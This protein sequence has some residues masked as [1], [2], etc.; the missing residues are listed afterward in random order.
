MVVK[1]SKNSLGRYRVASISFDGQDIAPKDFGKLYSTDTRFR[2]AVRTA[3]SPRL[4]GFGDHVW[5]KVAARMGINKLRALPDGDDAAKKQAMDDRVRNGVTTA[6]SLGDSITCDD[7][8]TNCRDG[9]GK[10][11]TDQEVD[12]ARKAQDNFDRSK[13]TS[14]RTA[15]KAISDAVGT[16]VT[17]AVNGISNMI[18]LTGPVDSYCQVYSAVRAV[19]YAAKTIRTVQ[20]ASYA[21][22]FLNTA[23]Q[24][25]AG[26]ATPED[27]A[28]LGGI[29][30]NV[31]YDVKSGV[32]RKAG[33]DSFG[34]KYVLH[35]EVGRADS[36][37]S[38]FMAG[39]G[40]TGDL[41]A[42]SDFLAGGKYGVPR[43]VCRVV[44]NQWVQVG[45]LIG[46][47]AIFFIPGANVAYGAS[48]I[49]KAGL[50]MSVAVGLTALAP[51]LIDIIAGN[52][53]ESIVGEDATNAMVSGSGSLFSGVSRA[54]GNGT[55]T[56]DDAVAYT[57]LNNEYIALNAV[58]DRATKSPLD[59]Y[60]PHTFLGSIVSRLATS[61][62]STNTLGGSLSTIG[63]ILSNS[64]Q[65][66]V[67]T[68]SAATDGALRIAYT[69]CQDTDYQEL[70]IATDP[71][72]NPIHGI[73]VKY[74]QIDP[75]TVLDELVKK[76]QID[77]VTGEVT[78]DEFKKIIEV[79]VD[80][81]EPLG[82]GGADGLGSIEDDKNCRINDDNA[83][84]FLYLVDQRIEEG[85]DMTSAAPVAS[86][87]S[88][89]AVPAGSAAELAQKIIDSGNV[90]DRSGQ[91]SQI[92][93]GS[94]TGVD[95]RVLAAVAALSEKYKFAI[96]SIQRDGNSGVEAGRERKTGHVG[97]RAIDISGS[98]GI[99]GES[100]SFNGHKTI[101]QEFLNSAAAALPGNCLIGVPNQQYVNATK[102]QV[103][104]GCGV[105][106]DSPSTTGATG[107]HVHLEVKP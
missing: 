78:G 38:Q 95:E 31:A 48:Q 103:K 98:Y 105:F 59:P 12:D 14:G 17:G 72:C 30:T 70:G 52:V 81:D 28:Y 53:T 3:Y 60:S 15:N 90:V 37:V 96:S 68:T 99:N 43:D 36:Y 13:Q 76:G 47:I 6:S 83:Y 66:L 45:S 87:D 18:K 92:A 5:N 51:M 104:T 82:S 4:A 67:P 26:T 39:G 20:L 40:L 65:S 7:A 86:T 22:I 10:P 61:A 64:F 21:M 2:S 33:M 49:V 32:K 55:M 41:I 91:L 101:V 23:D 44:L 46:G 16:P 42:I 56:V 29:I 71:F 25:K 9:D 19:G 8:G 93:S 62:S 54:G 80:S 74:L 75:L 100:Y 50:T 69:T 94:R 34:M 1:G 77:A 89:L 63:S 79:C 11:L 85:M 107:P 106:I 35:G 84:Y 24:I 58:E 102:P 88:D 73:P 27:V 57:N 97:G